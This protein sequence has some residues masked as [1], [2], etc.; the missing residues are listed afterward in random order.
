MSA[1]VTRNPM[2]TDAVWA[3]PPTALVD[4]HRR[5]PANA[6]T[7]LMDA[8]ALAWTTGA[9]AFQASIEA[10]WAVRLDGENR[11]SSPTLNPPLSTRPA[12]IRRSSNL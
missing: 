8:P 9:G 2:R 3:P 4:F 1:L 6:A 11:S 7:L 10:T 12:K 5:M